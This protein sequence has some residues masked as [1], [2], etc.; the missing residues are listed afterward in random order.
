LLHAAILS[1]CTRLTPSHH[2]PF[3]ISKLLYKLTSD[4]ETLEE[5]VNGAPPMDIDEPVSVRD[6]A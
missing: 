6:R 3:C 5:K 2:F 1:P 4:M